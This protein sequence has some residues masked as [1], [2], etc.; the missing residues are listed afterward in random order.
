M[1]LID[2]NQ[3]L[4]P[5]HLNYLLIFN[6]HGNYIY[7]YVVHSAGAETGWKSAIDRR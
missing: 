7:Q 4:L 3:L 1:A 6:L 2:L 5:S